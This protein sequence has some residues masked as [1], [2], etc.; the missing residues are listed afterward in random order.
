MLVNNSDIFVTEL[1][2]VS[3]EI[4]HERY[5]PTMDMVDTP[6]LVGA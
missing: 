4:L 6:L 3:Q 1:L 2:L 5:L